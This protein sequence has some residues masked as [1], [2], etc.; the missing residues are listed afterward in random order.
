MVGATESLAGTAIDPILPGL[1][2]DGLSSRGPASDGG[3]Q[4]MALH[5]LG[6]DPLPVAVSASPLPHTAGDGVIVTMIDR[7]E[8][9][10]LER[11]L[12]DAQRLEMAGQFTSMAAHDFRNYLTAIGG[13]ADLLADDLAGEREE[14]REIMTAVARGQ[15][16]VAAMLAFA[17]PADPADRTSGPPDTSTA[18]C[19]SSPT[20]RGLPR[21][22]SWWPSPIFPTSASARARSPKSS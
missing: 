4:V 1:D 18:S 2:T 5:R 22:S 6:G 20:W 12:L 17:R 13:F 11:R 3:R 9:Q 21:A 14:L 16:S 19:R 15:E 7:A 10:A 8:H